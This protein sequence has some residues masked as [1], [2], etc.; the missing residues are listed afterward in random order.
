MVFFEF[1]WGAPRG[2]RLWVEP[3]VELVDSTLVALKSGY[4]TSTSTGKLNANGNTG[5]PFGLVGEKRKK[6]RKV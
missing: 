5:N 1:F 2:N 6:E 4:D 3:L